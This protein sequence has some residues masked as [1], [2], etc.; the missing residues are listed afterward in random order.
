MSTRNLPGSKARLTTSPPTVSRLST[1]Y[2]ILDIS[3]P[4]TRRPPQPVTGM[5]FF[6]LLLKNILT[7]TRNFGKEDHNTSLTQS[8]NSQVLPWHEHI[9]QKKGT[10]W[11]ESAIEVFRPSG[12]SLSAKL[13]PT[14]AIREVSRSLRA[15]D[16]YGC[17]LEFLDRNRYFFFSS[18]SS[19]VLT[20]LSG[21]RSRLT[22]SQNIWQSRESN[23]D[24]WIC[25]KEL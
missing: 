23:P 16:P 8:L 18:S 22:T 11:P 12:R 2:G 5:A 10:P 7:Y 9:T 3:Q 6:L 20:G 15:V 21:R 14:F 19:V 24:L 17:N 25:S 4:Y 13:V 1:K